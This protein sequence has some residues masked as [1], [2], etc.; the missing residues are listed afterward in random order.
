MSFFVIFPWI[1]YF[2]FFRSLLFTLGKGFLHLQKG[3]LKTSNWIIM[4]LPPIK[5]VKPQAHLPELIQKNQCIFI[6]HIQIYTLSWLVSL[7]RERGLYKK[8]K[9]DGSWFW[10]A[11]NGR[12][13]AITYIKLTLYESLY[14][15][16]WIPKKM[17]Q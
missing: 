5:I 4:H 10:T 16:L 11:P 7:P 1:I 6:T 17:F 15:C 12:E 8:T 14:I 3:F 2:E 9:V 13:I